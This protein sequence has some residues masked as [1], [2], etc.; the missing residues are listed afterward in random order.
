MPISCGKIGFSALC[1]E[2]FRHF[3]AHMGIKQL[4]QQLPSGVVSAAAI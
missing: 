1:N 3:A 2:N 4:S